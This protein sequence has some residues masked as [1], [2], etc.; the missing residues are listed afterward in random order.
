MVFGC[1][2]DDQFIYECYQAR[3]ERFE[4][5]HNLDRSVLQRVEYAQLG[6]W[7]YNNPDILKLYR[8][9]KNGK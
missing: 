7:I 6:D 2:N 1:A 3:F 4:Y 8:K 9:W 5:L